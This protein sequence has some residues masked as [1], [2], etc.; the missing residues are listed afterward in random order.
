MNSSEMVGFWADWCKKYPIVSIEDGLAE[1]DWAGWK[2]V[3]EQLG[4]K[5]QLVGDDLFVT[6]TKRL[7]RG[8]EEGIANS[9]L[10]KVN[11]IGSLTETIEAVQMATRNGFTSVMSHRS[12]ETEDSTIADLAVAMNCGQIKT[13]SASRSDRMAKYNQLLRI[14][15]ELGDAAVYPGKNFRYL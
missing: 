3:T 4:S 5:V 11:Q 7:S 8:I 13:G 14:E 6:N 1:D 15:E 12:G 10:V 2:Q 9:I